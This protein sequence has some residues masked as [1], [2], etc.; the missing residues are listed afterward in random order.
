MVL[1][2]FCCFLNDKSIIIFF[3]FF[4]SRRR[5][6]RSLR[7]WSSDVCSSDLDGWVSANVDLAAVAGPLR[8]WR[9][10]PSNP[11]LRRRARKPSPLTSANRRLTEPRE[12]AAHYRHGRRLNATDPTRKNTMAT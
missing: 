6:T 8:R 2:W 7:D 11:L 3:F 4:S 5:H 9:P 10:H 12:T 1:L